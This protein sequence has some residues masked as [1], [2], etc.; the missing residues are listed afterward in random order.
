ML[1]AAF[2]TAE[3]SV[4]DLDTDGVAFCTEQFDARPLISGPAFSTL[5]FNETF[6]LIW[7]GSLITHLPERVTADFIAFALRHLSPA[8]VAYVA[9]R[10]PVEAELPTSEW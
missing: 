7:A 8:G 6:D 3:I 4:S 9:E 5:N 1:R 10:I 2:P